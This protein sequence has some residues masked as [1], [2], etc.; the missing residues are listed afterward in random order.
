[1][2]NIAIAGL[3]TVGAG[4]VRLLKQNAGTISSRAGKAIKIKA[5]SARNKGKKRDCD[6]TGIDWAEK[7]QALAEMEDVDVIV[8]LIGGGEGPAKQ[9]AEAALKNGKH[10]ITAN[11]ALI[12][13]HGIELA[14]L[15][16]ASK[17]QIAYEAAVAGGIPVIKALREGLSGNSL[18]SVRGI[19]NG[20][21]NYILTRMREGGLDFKTALAEAQKLGYAEADPTADVDGHDSANKLA[22]LAAL[23]FGS[24]PD[25]ASIRLEGIRHITPLDLQFADQLECRIKLLGVAKLTPMGLEQHVAPALIPK[26]SPLA[27]VNGPLN[28][29]LMRGDFVGDVMLE[30]QG[31]GAEPTASAV[32]ADIIDLARGRTTPA[33]GVPTKDLKTLPTARGSTKM[34]YYMRLQ[35]MDKPGVVAD[36]S[37]VIGS[38]GI[39]IESLIQRGKPSSGAVPVVVTTHEADMSAMHRAFEKIS[40]IKAVGL[41]PCLMQIEE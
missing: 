31:A 14:K 2:L 27:H 18:T 10:L 38:E 15:A 12:A 11:K 25:L 23:T 19:L 33:F 4:V 17:V 8:E 6:L 21:C 37:T 30:G 26:K 16:E 35:L 13:A 5:V 9:L 40:Q 36:I 28:A 7:P 1:M 34:R 3:G 24:K 39:S 22:I 41:H 20:T 32:V 29:V